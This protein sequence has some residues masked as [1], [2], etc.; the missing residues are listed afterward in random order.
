MLTANSVGHMAACVRQGTVPTGDE[1]ASRFAWALRTTM[2]LIDKTQSGPEG[3]C[4]YLLPISE[5]PTSRPCPFPAEMKIPKGIEGKNFEVYGGLYHTDHTVRSS[6][7]RPDSDPPGEPFSDLDLTYLY[8]DVAGN[9][10]FH[11]MSKGY[12]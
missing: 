11:E 2:S 5:K 3:R 12:K 6:F 1:E 10:D 4:T 9:D 7:F 8:D